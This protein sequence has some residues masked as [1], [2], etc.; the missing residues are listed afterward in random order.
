MVVD[1]NFK[2]QS[3][4]SLCHVKQLSFLELRLFERVHVPD[5]FHEPTIRELRLA[6]DPSTD[7]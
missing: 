4:I 2:L 1:S 3:V 5:F 6:P 7:Q